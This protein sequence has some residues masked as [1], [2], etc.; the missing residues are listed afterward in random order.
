MRGEREAKRKKPPGL[1]ARPGP[2]RCVSAAPSGSHK[3]RARAPGARFG[4][5][6]PRPPRRVNSPLPQLSDVGGEGGRTGGRP[7][8]GVG[9]PEGGPAAPAAAHSLQTAPASGQ[10]GAPRREQQQQ[11]HPPCIGRGEPRSLR[12]DP[13]PH[14]SGARLRGRAG[15]SSQVK[16][17][18]SPCEAWSSWKMRRR[19]GRSRR[20][21]QP[22]AAA[23]LPFRFH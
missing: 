6:P 8:R 11:Q 12:P 14:G 17:L 4:D 18:L 7:E 5:P 10:R 2:G 15:G 1:G 19:D 3:R 16:L 23:P 9:Q 22:P 13:S 20:R 21:L